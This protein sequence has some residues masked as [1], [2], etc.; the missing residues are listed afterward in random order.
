MVAY[1]DESK[2]N[3][4]NSITS[5]NPAL[6]KRIQDIL[7]DRKIRCNGKLGSECSAAS[8]L[9]HFICT[10]AHDYF[11]KGQSRLGHVQGTGIFG[12]MLHPHRLK[13]TDSV[14]KI[15]VKD[16][17]KNPPCILSK[18]KEDMDEPKVSGGD[19]MDVFLDRMISVFLSYLAGQREWEGHLCVGFG[20]TRDWEKMLKG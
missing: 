11:R 13:S 10:Q 12:S 7:Q 2:Q 20:W 1:A 18:R 14:K 9:P 6:H 4:A 8:L 5:G 17:V 15:V 19:G 16:S 3:C